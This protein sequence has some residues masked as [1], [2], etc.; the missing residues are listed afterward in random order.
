VKLTLSFDNGPSLKATPEV[1]DVLAKYHIKSTFFV[2]GKEI[3][4]Q[5]QRAILKRARQ[6]GHWIGNHTFSHTVQLGLSGDPDAPWQEIGR[7]QALLGDLAEPD[8]LFRP[9]G[10]G[11]FIGR[12]LLSPAALAFL[13][14]EKYTCVLWNSVPRDWEDILGWP[15]R[16]W[17]D[18]RS[19]AWTLLVLHDLPTGAMKQLPRF[20]EQV[21]AEGVEIVQAFPD[22]CVPIRRGEIV[23]RIDHMVAADASPTG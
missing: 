21:Q 6:E 3:L 4:G 20:L 9:Y 15:E 8:C 19:Q 17:R 13:L 12:Q 5:P 18:I 10:G 23:G 11:G 2:C 7:T 16:A 1:L 22:D 14:K